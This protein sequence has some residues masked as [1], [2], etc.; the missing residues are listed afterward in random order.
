M[1]ALDADSDTA[2][3]IASLLIKPASAVCNLDC[4]YCFYLDRD[5]DP[6]DGARMRTMPLDEQGWKL[7]NIHADSWVEIARRRRRYDFASKKT[8]LHAKC[9]ACEFQS[10]CKG[11]CP[12]TR[13]ATRGDFADLDWLCAGYKMIFSRAVIPLTEDL[14]RLYGPSA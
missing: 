6:Y 7:G 4:A 5:A 13:Q 10:I 11:G 2:P 3:K 14:K 9:A 8:L 1:R 12:K